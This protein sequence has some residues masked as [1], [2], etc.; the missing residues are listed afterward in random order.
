M[1]TNES[2]ESAAQCRMVTSRHMDI[3]PTPRDTMAVLKME[4]EKL[5]EKRPAFSL[6]YRNVFAMAAVFLMLAT[7]WLLLNSHDRAP[8][9]SAAA[10]TTVPDAGL[11]VADWDLE[12]ESLLTEV[13]SSIAL[14]AT[15]SDMDGS[16]YTV[17]WTNGGELSL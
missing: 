14:L 16:D 11:D 4:A 13:N 6:F 10:S 9:N 15:G 12:I 2:I 5:N 3:P 8:Q 1:K 7:G 17:D